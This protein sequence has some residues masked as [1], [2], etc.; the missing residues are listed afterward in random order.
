MTDWKAVFIGFL[1][2]LVFNV[3]GIFVGV[4]SPGLLAGLVAGYLAGR[5]LL[6]GA[7]HGLLAGAFGGIVLATLVAVTGL[8]Y[9][10]V[11]DPLGSI[12]GFGVALVLLFGML[13]FAVDSAIG[14]LLGAGV[15]RLTS[16]SS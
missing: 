6:S 8:G 16:S 4:I 2:E 14:G 3:L 12:V 10:L 7:W 9:G 5:G 13:L 15:A 11:V 1:A